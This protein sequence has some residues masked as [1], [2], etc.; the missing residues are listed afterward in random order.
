MV[1]RC[2][3]LT[4]V[5]LRM[6]SRTCLVRQPWRTFFLVTACLSDADC[7]SVILGGRPGRRLVFRPCSPS[8]SKRFI[9]KSILPW[10][11]PKSAAAWRSG[12][13]QPALIISSRS[14]IVGSFALWRAL[15]ALA[16]VFTSIT[17]AFTSKGY[18]NLV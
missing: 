17:A 8:F 18:I 15:F 14:R 3:Y 5:S 9:Q 2:V 1:C 10:V 11:Q 12:L 6:S 4:P 13:S 7:S 16:A